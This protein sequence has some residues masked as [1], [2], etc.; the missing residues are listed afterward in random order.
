MVVALV[1]RPLATLMVVLASCEM[2][3]HEDG[4][5]ISLSKAAVCAYVIVSSYY[6]SHWCPLSSSYT[7]GCSLPG[8]S[9]GS[10]EA[11]RV[12]SL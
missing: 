2:N 10:P 4:Q 5:D 3:G 7:E 1:L 12:H 11:Q 6:E 9:L 8:K